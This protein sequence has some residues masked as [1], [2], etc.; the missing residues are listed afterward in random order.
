MKCYNCKAEVPQNSLV[1]PKCGSPQKFTDLVE[2]AKK[3]DQDATTQLYRMTYNNV[4]ITIR[5]V[6][7][8]DDDTAFDIMQNTY[9]KAFRN[10]SQLKEPEAF[11][12]WIKAISRN[13]TIDHLRKKKVVL[14]SQMVSTDSDE[15]IDFEDERAE[16]LPEVVIDQNETKRLIDEILDGLPPEQ[17]IVVTMHL[18]E[19]ISVKEIAEAL[20]IPE[21]TVKSRLNY[22]KKKIKIEV[23]ELEKK[24][25]KLYGL[26]PIPFLLLLFRNQEVYA[27]EAPNMDIL[28]SV[29]SELSQGS[30]V[31][32]KS[33]LN[34]AETA[35]GNSVAGT[36][37]KSA[38][39]MAGKAITSKVI[40]GIVT[41]AVVGVGIAGV[42]ALNKNNDRA[43]E[44]S[45]V[46]VET[47]D[48]VL[49]EE[50]TLEEVEAAYQEIL[51][52]YIQACEEGFDNQEYP[53][54]SQEAMQYFERYQAPLLYNYKDI[55]N[56][57]V[58]EL[59]IGQGENEFI[60]L[61]AVYSYDGDEAIKIYDNF[62]ERTTVQI[63]KD[64]SIYE[65]GANSADSGVANLYKL[66]ED[67]YTLD[68]VFSYDYTYTEDGLI[69]SNDQET[70]SETEFQALLEGKTEV[71]YGWM[72]LYEGKN[73]SIS[74]GTIAGNYVRESDNGVKL[75]FSEL[76]ANT[77]LVESDYSGSTT[78]QSYEAIKDGDA[79]VI[80]I[81]MPSG[82]ATMTITQA[83]DKIVIEGNDIYKEHAYISWEGTYVKQDEEVTN[84]NTVETFA[85]AYINDSYCFELTYSNDILTCTSGE[86]P[87][88]GM[89]SYTYSS[90]EIEGNV[91]TA[92]HDDGTDIYVLNEDGSINA[93]FEGFLNYRSA[94][95]QAHEGTVF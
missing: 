44:S 93:T 56:N 39:N 45:Q 32:P 1:C 35:G 22:G 51:D 86:L 46:E 64:G 48:E 61:G 90:Y 66:N 95:Y 65:N 50:I 77:L 92:K 27:A 70:L 3:D 34:S 79:W 43:D 4:I 78:D 84:S 71:D 19:G 55:D 33:K 42:T 68:T 20:Q 26:A 53:D 75:I 74:S 8:L 9:I 14:F 41:V 80:S 82:T 83:G 29:Q 63:M 31:Q 11:R 94:D 73:E 81:D 91:L 2:R 47:T 10:L 62:N 36:A 25:T 38:V 89:F 24:G 72:T 54:V 28:Q 59:I 16:N 88:G 15:V 57:G 60:R 49:E 13:L 23:E 30:S 7:E 5:S 52:D 58:Y 21:G 69:Y 76:D 17:R 18:Y 40:A 37:T 87:Y 6:A 85:G 67:G 12:G